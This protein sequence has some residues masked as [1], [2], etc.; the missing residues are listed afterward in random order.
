M[1]S[2]VYLHVG[3]PKTGTTYLQSVLWANKDALDAQ[4]ILLPGRHA[5]DQMWATLV[6]REHPGL[7]N[8]KA[9]ARTSWGRIV[10]QVRAHEGPAVI[11]HEF[12]GAATEEQAARAIADLDAE[13]H[14]VVTA[15]D[16]LTVVASY[17][18][19]FVKHG[20][21]ER[22]L[23]DFPADGTSWEEWTWRTLDL[24][25][26]LR[27]WTVVVPPE[28][29]HL[30][31]LPDAS[32]PRETLWLQFAG[33]LGIADADTFALD[34]AREN[35]SLGVVEAEF[36]R[37]VSA[38]LDDFSTALDRGVWLRG[39]LAHGQLVGRGGDRPRPSEARVEELRARA[40]ATV[41]W[42]EGTGFDVQGDLQRLRVP[43]NVPGRD[44]ASVTEG[45][46]L[47]VA[48]ATV[49]GVLATM[50]TTRQ[51]NT[52][53]KAEIDDLAARVVAADEPAPESQRGGLR[54]RLRRSAEPGS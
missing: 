24:E 33:I 17:W 25:Q 32:E 46:L 8:R 21:F 27:R 6:V 30:L 13:V 10:E 48:T 52:R 53:L 29:V 54:R 26:V 11:S 40:D 1:A 37:R 31:V 39:F 7:P 23:D 44:P 49:R 2:R 28:R 12:F 4:G 19:E 15:R 20:F 14:L 3:L 18:Q 42:L 47:E 35:N 38:G 22:G 41:A 45:E 43:A 34:A 50:R 9:P 5:R 16:V 36:M 51:E